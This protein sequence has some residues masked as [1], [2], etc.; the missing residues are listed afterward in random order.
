MSRTRPDVVCPRCGSDVHRFGLDPATGMLQDACFVQITTA[1][2]T[3]EQTS[4]RYSFCLCEHTS[5][6]NPG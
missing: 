1:A 2:T 5:F 3:I 6:F 4:L